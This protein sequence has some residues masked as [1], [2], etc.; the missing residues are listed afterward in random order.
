MI[1]TSIS[2]TLALCQLKM[3]MLENGNISEELSM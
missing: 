2:F 3:C 1:V